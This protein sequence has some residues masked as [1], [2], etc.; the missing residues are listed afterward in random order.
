[1]KIRTG[2]VSNSS[3]SSFILELFEDNKPC[4]TCKRKDLDFVDL[5]YTINDG[6]GYDNRVDHSS[7]ESLMLEIE[8]RICE[9]QA[10]LKD[11]RA[12]DPN[13]ELDRWRSSF[14][15]EDIV[16][17]VRDRIKSTEEELEEW[18]LRREKIIP[19]EGRVV[20]CD[21]SYHSSLQDILQNMVNAGTAK[22]I[23]QEND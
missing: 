7:K 3:S 9:L 11:L 20:Q 13:R 23:E 22:I 21:I 16:T 10:Q 5:L 15:D 4:P 19:L 12:D 18:Q 8:E 17:R 1:M 14:K 2:F 6:G